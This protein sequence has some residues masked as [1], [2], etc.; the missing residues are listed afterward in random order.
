MIFVQI[1]I[2]QRLRNMSIKR[3]CLLVK[4]MIFCLKEA[5]EILIEWFLRITNEMKISDNLLRKHNKTNATFQNILLNW[6]YKYN[7]LQHNR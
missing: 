6:K 7:A 5:T 2:P 3:M 4:N 1:V